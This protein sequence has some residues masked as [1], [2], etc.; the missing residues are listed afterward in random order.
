M[1]NKPVPTDW[2]D[3][4]AAP[5]PAEKVQWREKGGYQLAYIS[6][7]DC[8]TRLDQVLGAENWQVSFEDMGGQSRL[9]CTVHVRIGDEW[10]G[11][12]D[13]SGGNEPNKGMPTQDANKADYSEA[14]K[15]ACVLWRIGRYL[16]LLPK[17]KTQEL[18]SWATPEGWEKFKKQ[19]E[20][21]A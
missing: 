13:G 17:S 3:Q 20:E 1:S 12:A 7:R 10:L 5:F 4:L 15:R 11:K 16:Y 6:A 18:P 9:T 19:R 8:M 21:K 14:F 2:S